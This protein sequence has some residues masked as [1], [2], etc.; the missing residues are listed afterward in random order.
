MCH[1]TKQNQRN[2]AARGAHQA[3]DYIKSI[4]ADA[5]VDF[6]HMACATGAAVSHSRPRS[7]QKLVDGRFAGSSAL[8]AN[9]G[10]E[11]RHD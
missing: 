2:S 8:P 11:V 10:V 9:S 3:I 4:L 1:E 6:E 7:P 5:N